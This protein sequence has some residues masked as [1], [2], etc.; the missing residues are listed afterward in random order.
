MSI[1]LKKLRVEYGL[2]QARVA[3][4]LGISQ[5]RYSK[6]ENN[7]VSMDSEMLKRI[8]E[9]YGVSADYLL[10]LNRA[11]PMTDAI[12]SSYMRSQKDI[13]TIVA[14]VVSIVKDHN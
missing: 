14:K 13:D 7:D 11:T 5:Q 3:Q 8:C 10:G 12:H 9:L 6:L 1:K 2:T 4:S